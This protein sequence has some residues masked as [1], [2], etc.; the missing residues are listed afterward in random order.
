MLHRVRLDEVSDGKVYGRRDMVR[1]G[2][3]DC[4]GCSECCRTVG[5]SIV[6]DPYDFALLSAELELTA[7]GL[8][9]KCTTFAP[10]GSMVL[11][12][13]VID[14]QSGCRLLSEDGRCTVHASRPG[15]CRLFPLAR[16]YEE[17]R[18]AYIHQIHEC[19]KK[20]NKKVRVEEFIGIPNMPAYERFLLVWDQ[21]RKNYEQMLTPDI[22]TEALEEQTTFILTLFYLTKFPVKKE[23]D[24][25]VDMEP[26]YNAF[27]RRMDTA[28]EGLGL[29]RVPDK[30]VEDWKKKPIRKTWLED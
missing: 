10:V 12:H 24:G 17:D 21:F 6:L 13:L 16:I 5:D 14:E 18:V 1:L 19:P 26:F 2:C 15:M 27:Y 22:S 23:A 3:G 30:E 29:V 11:P 25:H 8:N 20:P 4:D 9:R 28:Y 7:A